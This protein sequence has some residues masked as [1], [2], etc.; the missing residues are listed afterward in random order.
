VAERGDNLH[1][2]DESGSH[3]HQLLSNLTIGR[4]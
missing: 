4:R 1:H 2:Q 3:R